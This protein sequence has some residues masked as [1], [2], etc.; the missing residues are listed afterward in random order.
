V[1]R[2]A[3]DDAGDGPTDMVSSGGSLW[4]VSDVAGSLYR[5][6]PGGPLT[7][8]AGDPDTVSEDGPDTIGPSDTGGVW[9]SDLFDDGLSLCP[10]GAAAGAAPRTLPATY[11]GTYGPPALALGPDGRIY[12]PTTAAICAR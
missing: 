6:A 9:A 10:S 3:F 1:P 7:E 5:Y 2:T 11:R 12:Y 8:V 4:L